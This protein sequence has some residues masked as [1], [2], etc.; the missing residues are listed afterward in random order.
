MIDSKVDT[1]QE[2]SVSDVTHQINNNNLNVPE[3]RETHMTTHSRRG[4]GPN[5]RKYGLRPRNGLR[6]PIIEHDATEFRAPFRGRIRGGRT[7]PLSKY[8]RK[9]ANA[10]ERHRMKEINDAFSTL[11]EALPRVNT[12]RTTISGMTKITTLR[13]AV[14]YI[15][16]LSNIL[17]GE[18]I[19]PTEATLALLNSANIWK[20]NN[21]TLDNQMKVEKEEIVDKSECSLRHNNI[22]TDF[23]SSMLQSDYLETDQKPGW[24]SGHGPESDF[25]N[26]FSDNSDFI[27]DQSLSNFEE[28]P[29]FTDFCWSLT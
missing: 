8:R 5:S 6:R 14:N 22:S 17:N 3:K 21:C 18:N 2:P 11:R 10:R 25:V 12:R 27:S 23:H 20:N 15:Q 28:F 1:I 16:V 26:M 9:T 4:R 19:V 24:E 7:G 29:S 13:L